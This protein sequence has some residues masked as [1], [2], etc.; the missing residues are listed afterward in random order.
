MALLNVFLMPYCLYGIDYKTYSLST[1]QQEFLNSILVKIWNTALGYLFS[2]EFN[3]LRHYSCYISPI[4]TFVNI[5]ALLLKNKLRFLIRAGIFTKV[6]IGDIQ[7]GFFR[8]QIW[9]RPA[10]WVE[11]LKPVVV[12]TFF[13]V[14]RNR[15]KILLWYQKLGGQFVH[16]FLI[17]QYGT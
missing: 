4:H 5:P 7:Y 3:L 10:Y 15:P 16:E 12:T 17:Y 11:G 13:Y 6:W 1:N 2:F 8:G 14:I 9:P